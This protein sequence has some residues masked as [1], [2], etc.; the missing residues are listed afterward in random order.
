MR[1]SIVALCLIGISITLPSIASAWHDETHLAIPRAAG[2]AKWYNAAGADMARLKAGDIE[3]HNHFSNNPPGTSVT[4]NTVLNQVKDYN[5]ID[6]DG[7]LYGAIISTVRNYIAEKRTGKYRQ[8]HLAYCAH[9]VGD[10]SQPLHNIPY[11]DFNKKHHI[12][13]DRIINRDVLDNFDAI[14]IYPIAITSEKDLVREV[15]RIANI[16][17]SLGR[18]IEAEKRILTPAEAYRQIGHSASLFSAILKYVQ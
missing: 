1:K 8:Y 3:G 5:Q 6:R 18:R 15:A 4:P 11:N 12:A 9:Y 16:S 10:L 14:I 17:L 7:H 2:Y 13:I